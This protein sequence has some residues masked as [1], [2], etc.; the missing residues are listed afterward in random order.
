MK[1]IFL[2]FFYLSIF[3]CKLDK[4]DTAISELSNSIEKMRTSTA[5]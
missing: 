4:K 5:L 2:L 3:S 1:Q